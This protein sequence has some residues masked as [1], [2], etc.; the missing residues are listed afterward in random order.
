MSYEGYEQYWCKV[1]HYWVQD[2]YAGTAIECPRCHGE[3]AYINQV[4]Q[5][6]GPDE[7]KIEPQLISHER[8]KC[9][10]CGHTAGSGVYEIP[11]K[12]T[13]RIHSPAP[14]PCVDCGAE[15]WVALQPCPYEFLINGDQ[16][17]HWLCDDCYSERL[18]RTQ[19]YEEPL[20][21]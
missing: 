8:K 4:D 10:T 3:V 13:P 21:G 20:D 9:P 18:S 2:C 19:T 12:D 15:E 7:G 16:C 6:N 1:G 5:T 14:Q 11:T 17:P